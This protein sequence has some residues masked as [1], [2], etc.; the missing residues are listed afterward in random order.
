M[1]V[2]MQC[3]VVPRPCTYQLGDL[4]TII[5]PL[6]VPVSSWGEN[7]SLSQQVYPENHTVIHSAW[8]GAG[9]Q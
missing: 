2:M 5:Q 4:G 3:D 6:W 7:K 9:T 8:H 1:E